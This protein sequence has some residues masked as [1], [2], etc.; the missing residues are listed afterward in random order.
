MSVY[1]R[2]AAA[3][4]R[5]TLTAVVAVALSGWGGT[6]LAQAATAGIPAPSGGIG[7]PVPCLQGYVWRQAFALDYACVTP[8]TRAQAAADD[9]AAQ[10]RVQPGGGPY[11]QYTCVQGYV[12][13]QI[14]PTDYVCV[15]PAV[16]SQ[17][18]YDNSQAPDRYLMMRLWVT[19]WTP[20][21]PPSQPCTGNVCTVTEGGA[22][23]PNIQLNGDLFNYGK[24]KLYVYT[25]GGRLLASWTPTAASYPGYPGGAFGWH[26][27]YLNCAAADPA[28]HSNDY[29]IARDLTS[30]RWSKRLAIDTA[31][32]SL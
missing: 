32:A 27:P 29:V 11:G 25:N 3:A 20:P 14:V 28:S 23:G 13:R 21:A 5:I 18:A 15:T 1:T 31:C 7:A 10:S 17:A 8:A 4:G 9:A 16:R 6:A 30:G 2:V 22:D 12:W 19:S 26:T 24:V